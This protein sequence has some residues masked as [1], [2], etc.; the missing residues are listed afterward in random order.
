MKGGQPVTR[1]VIRFTILFP[2][3]MDCSELKLEVSLNEKETAKQLHQVVFPAV[4]TVY[5]C[6]NC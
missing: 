6:D 5:Y 1:Q 2:W 3:Q 4:A